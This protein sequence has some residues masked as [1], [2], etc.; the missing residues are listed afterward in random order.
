MPRGPRPHEIIMLWLLLLSVDAWNAPQPVSWSNRLGL[1]LTPISKGVWSAERRNMRWNMIDVG[2][3]TTLAR[4]ASGSLFVH[5][6]G[7][8]D[9]DLKAAIDALGGGVSCILSS[10]SEADLA[11]WKA[12]FP[13]AEFVTPLEASDSKDS[14]PKPFSTVVVEGDA[15]LERKYGLGVSERV[16]GR[17][18]SS[19]AIR[20]WMSPEPLSFV[21]HESSK[22]LLCGQAWWNFPKRQRP[23]MEDEAGA[24]GT[25]FVWECSKVPVPYD[26]LPDVKASKRTRLWAVAKNAVVWPIRRSLMSQGGLNIGGWVLWTGG[27]PPSRALRIYR[28][29][30]DAV[31]AWDFETLVPAHG[32]VLRGKVACR[33]AIEKHFLPQGSRSGNAEVLDPEIPLNSYSEKP[34]GIVPPLKNYFKVEMPASWTKEFEAKRKEKPVAD[35][36]E[37]PQLRS[38]GGDKGS[39]E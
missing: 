25:G 16:E 28:E 33:E 15:Q 26:L 39:E 4:T 17:V 3:R 23:N 1:T 38:P 19:I 24:E 36:T 35:A 21:Y 10:Q 13:V 34:F 29:Q 18:L 37:H 32:D 30:V 8:L 27:R 12:A 22:T 11:D 6:P 7:P 2:R 31:L 14:V 5:A 9:D 20:P